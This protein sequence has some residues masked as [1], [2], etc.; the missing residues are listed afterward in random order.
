MSFPWIGHA[1]G[2]RLA[3]ALLLVAAGQAS[4]AGD[5]GSGERIA[6]RWCSGCHAV[7]AG[8]SDAA[9][10]FTEIVRRPDRSPSFLHAWLSDPH[11]PMP[12]LDLSRQEIADVIAYLST[13]AERR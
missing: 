1:A 6:E 5:P 11:P 12:R 2:A 7:T 8:G 4:A 3:A 9:P 13:L 10:P